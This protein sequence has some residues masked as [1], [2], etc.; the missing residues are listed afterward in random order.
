[1][2][3]VTH[4][5]GVDA[6][7]D[8]P[9]PGHPTEIPDVG[10]DVGGGDFGA[11]CLSNNDC[12]SGFCVEGV[13]GFVCTVQCLEE[14]P[15]G[16]VCRGIMV[17]P[18]VVSLCIPLGANLCK[19]CKLDTQCGDGLCMEIGDGT[20][21]G[22]D[23]EFTDCP[24]GYG[25]E[26]VETEG[27]TRFQC[28]PVSGA[29][30]CNVTSHGT[31][32]PCVRENEHGTC[33]GMETCDK[34]QGWVGCTAIDALPEV[35][36][37]IDDDC[38]GP[39]DET[40]SELW[41]VCFAGTGECHATGVM[42]CNEAGDGVECDAEAG[43]PANEICDGLD[44]DCDVHV[45][46]DWPDKGKV[47]IVGEGECRR[48]GTFVCAADG[49]GIECNAEPGDPADE[50]CN[51][52]DDDCD[53]DVDEDWPDKGAVCLSGEGECR[54][55]GTFVCTA[56]GAGIECDAEPGEPSP[57]VCDLLD[58]N[59]DG[60]TDEPF[61]TGG[62]YASD[63]ACGNC[64]TDCTQI[65]AL[66]D[67]YGTCDA[68]GTPVCVMGC[69]GGYYDLNGIPDDGCE[70]SLDVD[71]IYVSVDDPAAMNDAQCGL[72]PV[73]TIEGVYPCWS[74]GHG[75]VRSVNEG[76][77]KVLVADGLYEETVTLVDGKSVLGGFR[78]D[79]WER[80][81]DSTLA[82]VRGDDSGQNRKTIVADGIVSETVVEGLLVYGPTNPQPRGNSYAIW[83]LDGASGLTIRHNSIHAGAGGPGMNGVHG[84]NGTGG[85]Q[86]G[87]GQ[88]AKQ[89]SANCFNECSF[90][91]E[92]PGG[93]GG[94]GNCSGTD[95]SGGVGGR[96]VCPDFQESVDLCSECNTTEDQVIAPASNGAQGANS[97]GAG[98]SGGYDAIIDGSCLG[99]CSC[100]VPVGEQDGAIGTDGV[101]GSNGDS[102]AGCLNNSGSVSGGEW[103]G[104]AGGDGGNGIHGSGAGG[105]GAGGGVETFYYSGCSEHGYTDIG[106]SGGG[107]GSAGCRGTGGFGGTAG[108]AAFGVF[109][110]WT[111]GSAS[112]PV[113]VS[114]EVMPGFGG[115]GGQGGNGGT[116]GP[117][118]AG[119]AG[120]QSGSGS[121]GM[122]CA[123]AGGKGG[124]GG[125]GGHGG[126]G[127]GGCGGASY[128]MFAW[129]QEGLDLS[130]YKA[131]NVFATGGSGGQGGA[132]GG[133]MGN[134][135]SNASD[136]TSADFN[137]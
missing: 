134:L 7:R 93:N 40:F 5:H 21:C 55:A 50:M 49:A 54:R 23:C 63:T 37:G 56:D 99:S 110:V 106:G 120:G 11:P 6:V 64:F 69:D 18:D 123:P 98:G 126:G 32:R 67:A 128:G 58:N 31:E 121:T 27:G 114:N 137:F 83:I 10:I 17:G 82:V 84:G 44:N 119:A 16:W 15:E 78:A 92:T 135:G 35:C 1:M 136:G 72:G 124:H 97:G 131:F 48:A 104:V 105:G 28:L 59:C 103:I 61:K 86:G 26:A 62:E 88:G 111:G 45:D 39:T 74:I 60:Q 91:M 33:L 73:D 25:C 96:A 29:C 41:K 107:G 65:Y 51:G 95:V 133:S 94:A 117:G 47:C 122:F 87:P 70:L 80:H 77:G 53:D 38:D 108:G 90:G 19:S 42:T 34:D 66:P 76:R 129:G 125:D 116:G 57:E 79:T 75:L 9:D 12:D 2:P 71:A 130:S 13:E 132:G 20:F 109:L 4:D 52:L 30:D 127:G 22:K 89:I 36:N 8:V 43:E 113:I 102:G 81:I 101:D 115:N 68:T 112:A 14:C 46:E 100:Y 3:D 85:A 118:G 24:A